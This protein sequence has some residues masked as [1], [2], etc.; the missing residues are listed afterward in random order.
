MAALNERKIAFVR[1]LVE[2]APDKVVGGLQ[3][4]LAETASDSALGGVRRLVE[5][6]VRER[7]LRNIVLQPVV[8]MCLGGGDDTRKLTFPS[9]ALAHVWRALRATHGE[10]IE[11]VQ[12]DLDEQAPIHTIMA[13]FD[14]LS[15]AATAGLRAA[16][17]PDYAAAIAACDQ[18]RPD[19]GGMFMSCLDIA[20]VV[21]RATQRLPEWLAH[22]GG[23]TSAAA[24]LAYKDA[25]A[26]AE[27]SGPRFFEMLAA[28]MAQPW[29]VLRVI[30]AVMD[31][32]TERYLRD[33]ELSSFGE[34]LLADIDASLSAIG[35][36][37]AD[38]G[39]AAASEAARLADLAVHQILE[40]E[41]SLDLQREQGWGQRVFKQRAT[42]ASV[43]EGR[44]RE[45]EKAA[46][47]ALPTHT[48]RQQRVR[49]PVPRLVDPPQDKL[50]NRAITLLSFSDEL[51]STANYGG[52]SSTRN[53]LIE[54]L[55]EHLD[56]YV[57][58][59]LD[60]IRNDECESL[61]NAQAFLDIAAR[62]NQH[63][64]GDKAAE[65]VRRRA[66]AVHCAEPPPLADVG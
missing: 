63:I 14:E 31:K 4:A 45:A 21:R 54:K 57:E 17:S 6:E 49:R 20:P 46:I 53:K 15:A 33:S 30:S 64:R 48:P 41:T 26:I 60:L 58:E 52:F 18:G 8:P 34:H 47:E 27:D 50:V 28:Q 40:V 19:G 38:D 25:V 65:I 10:T 37:K 51:R 66:H 42:L 61:Q 7:T 3:A 12:R 1:S 39:P 2:T 32:P 43:V 11:H 62:F 55:G 5:A 13:L 44:L 36:L 35:A 16:G 22:P 29:M 59:V 9:K 24:R 56:H 23:E